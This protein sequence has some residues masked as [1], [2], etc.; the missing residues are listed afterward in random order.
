MPAVLFDVRWPDGATMRL[1]SP[2]TVV[3]TYFEAGAS[4]PLVDFVSRARA[5]MRAAGERVREV[6]G[7]PC[8]RAAA[9]L[10]QIEAQAA[11]YAPDASVAVERIQQ[12]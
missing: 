2:S 7:F 11:R 8:S 10:R 4:Y 6:H 1:Y 5:S 12:G 3:A 9:T